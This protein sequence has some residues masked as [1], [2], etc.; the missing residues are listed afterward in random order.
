MREPNFFIVGA[1]K[2]GTTAMYNYLS[3]HPDIF[4]PEVKEPHFFGSDIYAPYFIRDKEKYLSIFSKA[5]NE[6]R[7]GEASVWSLYSKHAASEIKACYP[8]ASIIIMLRNP[9]DMIYS[10]HSQRLYNCT[11]DITDFEAALE[12]EGQRK[13]SLLLPK[14]PYP[15]HGL[16]YREIAKYTDQVERFL[17]VFDHK[18]VKIIIFDDFKANTN[19]SYKE[20]LQF[21]EVDANF[22]PEIKVVN[23]NKLPRSTGFKKLLKQPPLPLQLI[24]RALLP[25]K[26]L[27][28]K[29]RTE[30]LKRNIKYVSRPP[31]NSQ[32]RQRLQEEFFEDI[33][34]LSK[35]LNRDLTHW[36]TQQ[37]LQSA[38]NSLIK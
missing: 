36:T 17:K 18:Q 3:Q 29:L 35:L 9:V 21:L 2:C 30:I 19:Q 15:I 26:T 31:M 22:Q 23:P 12:A 11:E 34:R 27:R 5:K 37:K 4:M 25:S 16:F 8:D 32:L 38:S 24:I 14:F 6:K 20:L 7:V 10:Y 33:E 1:P 28:T 13:Q